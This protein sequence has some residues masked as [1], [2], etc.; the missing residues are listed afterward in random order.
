MADEQRNGA[1]LI[2]HMAAN[3][4]NAPAAAPAAAPEQPL[5]DIE[6]GLVEGNP[7]TALEI[8]VQIVET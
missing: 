7:N 2:P 5:F 8:F 1:D 4:I 6:A 3:D